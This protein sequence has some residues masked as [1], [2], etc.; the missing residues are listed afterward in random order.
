MNSVEFCRCQ[1]AEDD[2][3][4]KLIHVGAM[5]KIVRSN[6]RIVHLFVLWVFH[7]IISHGIYIVKVMPCISLI[8]ASL[9]TKI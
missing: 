8:G 9:P 4:I 6:N 1:L 2:E 5:K 3:I 7:C